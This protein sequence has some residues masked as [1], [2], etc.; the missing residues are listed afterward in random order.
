MTIKQLVDLGFYPKSENTK[1]RI[2]FYTGNQIRIPSYRDEFIIP[3]HYKINDVID[4]LVDAAHKYGIKEGET[5]KVD[6][7]KS[8]LNIY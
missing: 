3:V 7:I 6:Q 1:N 2:F 8:I 5:R 4:L